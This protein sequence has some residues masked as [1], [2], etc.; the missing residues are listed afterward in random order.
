[1]Q[2]NN[3]F[4]ARARFYLAC[5]RGAHAA[6]QYLQLRKAG[7]TAAVALADARVQVQRCSSVQFHEVCE[8]SGVEIVFS[9]LGDV[10]A[11]LNGRIVALML[12]QPDADGEPRHYIDRYLA[13]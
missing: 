3:L 7:A 13:A 12:A 9:R 5:H 6:A 10:T 11:K 8:R 2:R 1:M 4:Q